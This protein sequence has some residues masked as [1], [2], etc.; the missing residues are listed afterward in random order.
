[1]A[2]RFQTSRAVP[3][4]IDA[5]MVGVHADDLAERNV[6]E[7]LD[8]A[9]LSG[10][11]FTGA[12]G[13]V[14][15]LPGLPL[16]RTLLAVGLGHRA[17]LTPAAYRKIGAALAQAS[18]RHRRLATTVLGERPDHVDVGEAARALA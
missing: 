10:Q 3:D 4:A 8:A 12:L 5:L 13:E 9:Y 18:S 16:G 6:P 17:D 14:R 7:P 2:L 1:M 11:G 15:A